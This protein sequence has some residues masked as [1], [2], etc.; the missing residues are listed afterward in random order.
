MHNQ[1]QPDWP[2]CN[3][4][5]WLKVQ[6]NSKIFLLSLKIDQYMFFPVKI[7]VSTISDPKFMVWNT[8]IDTGCLNTGCLFNFD[9]GNDTI[10][11]VPAPLA[12]ALD[13]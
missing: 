12:V 11:T 3:L 5:W 8:F 1:I 4:A 13:Y 6:R 2:K 9:Y 10:S 7:F